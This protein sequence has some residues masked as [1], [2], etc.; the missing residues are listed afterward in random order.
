MNILI[1]IVSKLQWVEVQGFNSIVFVHDGVRCLFSVDLIHRCYQSAVEFGSAIPVIN[2]KD[3]VR[4]VLEQGNEA[5]ERDRVKLVQTPQTF[6]S[7]ILLPA[8]GVDY[9][10]KFTDEATV[11]EAFGMK[12]HLVVGEEQN[13]K[14][15][16]PIDLLLAEGIMNAANEK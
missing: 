5:L 10:D 9:Q 2:S 4:L 11:V 1:R 12:V 7:K 14:I 13:I 16:Q 8:F 3:S 6:Q 15:T